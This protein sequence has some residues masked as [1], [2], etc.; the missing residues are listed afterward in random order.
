MQLPATRFSSEAS[1][2]TSLG[3]DVHGNHIKRILGVC[4]NET[5]PM[6]VIW[7]TP[8]VLKRSTSKF[9]LLYLVSNL[10]FLSFKFALQ[11]FGVQS[12]GSSGNVMDHGSLLLFRLKRK[13]GDL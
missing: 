13:S 2:Y 12:L 5:L 7:Q 11:N 4:E 10:E 9:Q 1:R 8:E 6:H 3:A